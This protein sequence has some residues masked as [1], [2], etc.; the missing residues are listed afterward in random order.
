M[1]ER[2]VVI[3]SAVALAVLVLALTLLSD[4]SEPVTARR[5]IDE[6]VRVDLMPG[7][8]PDR[9]SGRIDPRG[10]AKKYRISSLNNRGQLIELFGDSLVPLPEGVTKVDAPG[11]RVHLS[12][13]RVLQIRAQ[14]GTVIAP[15]NQLRSGQFDG[16]VVVTMFETAPEQAIDY[17]DGSDDAKLHLF[18][19]DARF[20]LELGRIESDREVHMTGPA[21][22]FHGE[23]LDLSY[24]DMRRRIDRLEVT[25]GQS[26]RL[27]S[28][29]RPEPGP[30]VAPSPPVEG[31]DSA[32]I[33]GASGASSFP[34][35]ENP[36]PEVSP[37][38][39][40]TKPDRA[41]P[42][43]Y[44]RAKFDSQV[45]VRSRTATIEADR[46][47]V[48]FSMDSQSDPSNIFLGGKSA[49]G[50][51]SIRFKPAPPD[52]V[53]GMAAGGG[54]VLG[55][56]G[57][58]L[59]GAAAKLAVLAVAQTDKTTPEAVPAEPSPDKTVA[60][61]LDEVV[62]TWSGR[63]LVEP[64]ESPPIDLTGP[65]DMLVQMVGRPVRITTP[66]GEV[67]TAASV[68]Y[69][70]SDGRVRV[71][72]SSTHP[73]RIA[74]P[75]VGVLHGQRL[76]IHQTLG[77]GQIIGAGKLEAAGSSGIESVV[78]GTP[79]AREDSDGPLP[80]LEIAW[81]D[82]VDLTFYQPETD[83][84]SGSGLSPGAKQ[85]SAMKE[86]VFRGG[87][88]VKHPRLTLDA[89][90]LAV[91][92]TAPG[93]GDQTIDAIEAAGGVVSTVQQAHRDQA[94]QVRSDKLR[95]EMTH[96]GGSVQ[97]SRLLASGHVVAEQLGRSLEA[98]Q[99]EVSM[100][101][102]SQGTDTAEPASVDPSPDGWGRVDRV[103]AWDDV[104]IKMGDMVAEAFA[105]RLEADTTS[106]QVELFGRKDH[107][108]RVTR[109]GDSLLGG[110]IVVNQAGESVHVAGPGAIEFSNK[111]AQRAKPG[112][113]GSEI[114]DLD[115]AP[116][117]RGS[118]VRVSWKEAMN[119]D[120]RFGLAQFVGDVASQ[121]QSDREAARLAAQDL[122]IEFV[123]SSTA[124]P[125]AAARDDVLGQGRTVRMVTAR[126]KVVFS[127]TKWAD[128]LDGELETRLRVSG[129]FVSFDNFSEQ[130]Q[131][132]GP[133]KMLI[134]DYR[135]RS[136]KQKR[137]NPQAAA[138]FG[139]EKSGRVRLTGRGATLLRWTGQLSLDAYHNDMRIETDVQMIHRSLDSQLSVQVD[140][141]RLL[142]DLESTG[143]LGVWFAGNATQPRLKAVYADDDVRVLSDRRTIR[144]DHLEYTGFDQTILL[145]ANEG[146]TT[147]IQ[148]ADRPTTLSAE[149][150]RWELEHNRL[151]AVNL[152]PTRMQLR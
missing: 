47:D 133:G 42:A 19:K 15:D 60:D 125:G 46:L 22:E 142:S 29:S 8:D 122:R 86:A 126:E 101:G 10:Q 146:K 85:V 149:R 145:W 52:R 58:G 53:Q 26:L 7:F 119:F 123:E 130:I 14:K 96:G 20:D 56:L 36:T 118:R 105:D 48:V 76:V 79:G 68:D 17:S 59:Q 138:L 25:H 87:V 77:T 71:F 32:T 24:N 66:R 113:G 50:S 120:N 124:V 64:E 78:A 18:L 100:R 98:G 30:S 97:P 81:T 38:A 61:G 13:Q 55:E 6:P 107:P 63:L 27:K 72:G 37:S 1:V 12:D 139:T 39:A 80:N 70:D 34:G 2:V 67:I 102:P 4:P 144:T 41:R 93:E 82:R 43:Q 121:T 112:A 83:S 94:G 57:G 131:V 31:P 54:R 140:C 106:D 51:S 115:Q 75:G 45:R 69:L 88:R 109:H 134:E 65:D 33:T 16:D 73:M 40:P 143:G 23:G 152:G 28:W 135:V 108:A 132:V 148:D 136:E 5:T 99:L 137:D 141:Q 150:F 91:S 21:V 117:P 74:T 110:H 62:I 104:R 3:G 103:A 90:E 114:V 44:Y 35:S 89:D 111:P 92:L 127:T 84:P 116:K 147:E 49:R 11:A 9:P 129:P 151:E 128:K 95:I